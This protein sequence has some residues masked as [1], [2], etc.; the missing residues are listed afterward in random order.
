M[1][2]VRAKAEFGKEEESQEGEEV[3]RVEAVVGELVS[4]TFQCE[5]WSY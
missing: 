3:R 2:H 5:V 4:P 1:N